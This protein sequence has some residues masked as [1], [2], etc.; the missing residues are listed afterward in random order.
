[1]QCKRASGQSARNLLSVP[2]GIRLVPFLLR[3][4]PSRELAYEMP[5]LRHAERREPTH[6]SCILL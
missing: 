4:I 6:F 2:I 5:V 1:M 3:E